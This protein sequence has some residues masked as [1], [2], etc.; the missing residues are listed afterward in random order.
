MDELRQRKRLRLETWDYSKN[1]AYF[2]TICTK[3]HVELLWDTSASVGAALSRPRLSELGL[4]VDEELNRIPMI[5]ETVI[6]DKYVIMPN[7][8]H[9]V[10]M[11]CHYSS[12]MDG[13]LR[14]A[15]TTTSTIIQQTKMKISKRAGFSFWQ[16]SFYDHIIRSDS[17][18]R[19]IWHYIDINPQ[20]WEEDP[21]YKG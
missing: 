15:P 16:K 21:Y 6:L 12:L 2:I 7:H 11:I 18:Y 8:I 5:Y 10:L 14:A 19:R 9:L 1:G 17:D 13:R 3:Q 4:S 20:K